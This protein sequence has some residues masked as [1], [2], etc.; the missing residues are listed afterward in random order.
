[1]AVKRLRTTGGQSGSLVGVPLTSPIVPASSLLVAE[2]SRTAAAISDVELPSPCMVV[3][4]CRAVAAI[5][6]A[7]DRRWT[8]ASRTR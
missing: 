3:S 6:E 8:L 2:I 1:M 4:C 7:V 5:S